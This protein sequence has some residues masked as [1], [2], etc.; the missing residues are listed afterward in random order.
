[1][2][3]HDQ[4]GNRAFGD[5]LSH[6]AGTD[7]LCAAT[8]LLLFLPMTPLLFMGQEWAASSPFAYFTDHEPDYGPLV[9]AGRRDE[10]R[11]FAAFADPTMR[12]R[13]PDP[14]AR[15]TFERSRLQWD[16]R[17]Q[18]AHRRVLQTVRAML[19]LRRDDA[20]LR[21]PGTRGAGLRARAIDGLLVVKRSSDAGRRTLVAN[22][23]A[24]TV[25]TEAAV[26]SETLLLCVGDVA[27]ESMGPWSVAVRPGAS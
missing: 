9:S 17:D 3:N 23:S 6:D 25:R 5:R 8:V 10:F 14:Q 12:D 7:A 20:V 26:A 21:S 13:I 22:L 15:G 4:I 11:K 1:M 16:E 18:G 24:Q 19:R 27:N 2:E